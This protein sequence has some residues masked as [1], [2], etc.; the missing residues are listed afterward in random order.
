MLSSGQ[1]RSHND[2]T[3]IGPTLTCLQDIE[4][5][6]ATLKSFYTLNNY[7]IFVKLMIYALNLQIRLLIVV[8]TQAY[9]I[10]YKSML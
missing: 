8:L 10:D 3:K 1:F 4:Q 6:E 2:G 7:D 5:V 9:D